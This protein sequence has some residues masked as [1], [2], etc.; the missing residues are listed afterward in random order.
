[1][2]VFQ[3][4]GLAADDG[5]A[6]ERQ[7]EDL[8]PL[9]MVDRWESPTVDVERLRLED[10]ANLDRRDI[11]YRIG[12]PMDTDL[13]PANSGSWEV[14]PSG[15]RVWRLKVSTQ[16]ALWTVLGFGTFRLQEGGAMTVYDPKQETV[17]GPYTSADIRRHGE[18][19]FPP[20]AGD[21]LV[22]EVFWPAALRDEQP[23]LHLTTVSHGYKPYGVI[24]KAILGFGDSGPCNI[25]TMCPEAADWQDEKRAIVSV[26][27]GG[28]GNCS[29]Q[30]LNTTAGDCRTYLLTASH[31]GENGPSTT[32]AFNYEN[33]TCGNTDPSVVPPITNQTLTGGVLLAD[34]TSSDFTL[35][36]MDEAPPEEFSAYFLGWSAEPTPAQFTYVISHPRGDVK[37]IAFDADP[38]VD[39]HNY[40]P[41]HWR[42]ADVEDG[43]APETYGYEWGTTEPASSGSALMDHNHRVVGQLHGGT[44]SCTSDTWDEYGKISSSWTGGG[45][46]ETSLQPWLDPLATGALTVDGVDHSICLYQPA[47]EVLFTQDLYNCGDTLT[48]TL[49]DDNIPGDPPTFDVEVSS[50]TEVVEEILT[51]TQIEPGVGRYIGT[52]PTTTLP[53]VNGDGLLSVSHGDILTALFID[54]DDGAGGTNITV[55]DNADV[56]CASPVISNVQVGDVTG[57]AATITWDTDEA[58]DSLVTYGLTPPGT[59]TDSDGAL[60][61]S[62]ELRIQG[63]AECSPYV[64]WVA[65]TDSVGN[66]ATD[67]NSGEYYTFETG[68]KSEPDY[69]STDTPIPISDNTTHTSTIAVTDDQTVLGIRVTLNITHTYDGDLDITLINP[70]GTRVLL[71][72]DRGGTGENFVNTVFDDDATTP[73]GSGS[74]PFTGSF[75]PE[76][77]LSGAT[78][79][80][81]LGDWVLEVVDDAGSDT[82]SLNDWTLTLVFPA[83]VCGPSATYRDHTLVA[84]VCVDGAG[85]ANGYWDAGETVEFGVTVRND[86]TDPLS[87]IT[88]QVTPLTEGVIV[89][90]SMSSYADVAAGESTAS[91][92]SYSALLPTG[93]TCGA[94]LSFKVTIDTNEGTWNETFTQVNGE[95]IPGGDAVAWSEDFE[96]AGGIPV[97][98]TIVDGLADGNTWYADDSSDPAGCSNTDPNPPLAGVWAAVDSDCTGSGVTMDEELITPL[99]DLTGHT[100]VTLQFDHY[101]NWLGP[102]TGDLD[103]RSSLTGGLWVT[104]ASWTADTANPEHVA[105]DISAQAGGVSDLQIRWHYYNADY[106]WYWY[107]D[108]IAITY[109]TQ[110]GCVMPVCVASAV[111]PPPIPDG[112]ANTTPLLVD[113]LVGDGTSLELVWDDQCAPIGTKVIYGPIGQVST[114]G[115]TGSVCS[116]SNPVLWDPVPV[117]S[118]WFLLVS[119]DGLGIEGS[120]GQTA[121]VERNGLTHSNTCGSTSKEINGV[122]P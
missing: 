22:V 11:P 59:D 54:A 40:G 84:D 61:V 35:I 86:G 118:L 113:R 60:V 46:P 119:D 90:D 57:S 49:R 88:A 117:E 52:M 102:E 74:A 75:Q 109:P 17:M 6:R 30:L 79:G 100:D 39:G 7:R 41:T 105:I 38:P 106:E 89:I 27:V 24:G 47:G 43:G 18:L 55:K 104:V 48:I 63:L 26:L 76:Q 116:V 68:K 97:D 32:I 108:N 96:V 42:I 99:I 67:D 82:G 33:P 69:P 92:S 65:S 83:G 98:W 20:I 120:W 16:G 5:Q 31:C 10:E 50:A 80:S 66:T 56:D 2:L 93:L 36:E 64:Y 37:K 114:L 45:T 29:G 51:L 70:Q 12:F 1:M 95:V 78:G 14:L 94:D 9:S 23:N 103:V 121:G 110:A 4:N 111:G 28:S 87:G 58:A 107:V 122:C 3:A 72:A 85:N 115:I 15:D 73:I 8:M 91:V 71:V 62:H 112:S 25:D 81:S 13:S 19:W 44:A 34:W 21:T 77:P 53:P 101:F